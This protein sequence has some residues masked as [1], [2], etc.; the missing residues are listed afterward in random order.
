MPDFSRAPAASNKDSR[1]LRVKVFF[2]GRGKMLLVAMLT[3]LE[4]CVLSVCSLVEMLK[5][6]R[7]RPVPGQAAAGSKAN[8]ATNNL[9]LLNQIVNHLKENQEYAAQQKNKNTHLYNLSQ[10]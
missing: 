3:S 6:S 5:S 4:G 2:L 8:S 7:S 10:I 1:A 9:S